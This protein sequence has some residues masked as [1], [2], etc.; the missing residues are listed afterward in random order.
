MRPSVIRLH[1]T[2]FGPFLD[3]VDNPSQRIG[4]LLQNRFAASDNKDQVGETCVVTL[5]D[6]CTLEVSVDAVAA[7]FDKGPLSF[8]N[9]PE[10]DNKASAASVLDLFA[11]LG[12]HR[13]AHGE[14]RVELQGVND[15]HC[16]QGDFKGRAVI[17]RP[18]VVVAPQGEVA[19][20][21]LPSTSGTNVNAWKPESSFDAPQSGAAA[22]PSLWCTLP[23]HV[24][25]ETIKEV[26]STASFTPDDEA[27][28][29]DRRRF[30]V[31]L[32]TSDDAGRYLC[33]YCYCRSLFYTSYVCHSREC[34]S[35]FI[36]VLDPDRGGEKGGESWLNP[37]IAEQADC[38]FRFLQQ[39]A[40][41]L[42][43]T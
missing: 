40:K 26:G 8:V 37:S 11:H 43:S 13:G 33:N 1:V 35:L 5:A 34:Y 6:H 21:A 42:T 18:I 27:D 30:P 23:K 36:H 24:I 38:I 3:V 14:I 16:P 22:F 9:Q 32:M 12:V 7:Y 4:E 10:D 25:A 15:L 17:H 20:S 28:P 2:S 39:L 19:A 31:S 29:N 41:Q